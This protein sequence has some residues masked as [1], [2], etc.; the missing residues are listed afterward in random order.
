M[1][2]I[3]SKFTHYYEAAIK[4]RVSGGLLCRSAIICAG[5]DKKRKPYRRSIIRC[6]TWNAIIPDEVS[7]RP[8]VYLLGDKYSIASI[9]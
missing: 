3:K 6:M 9:K 7:N 4:Q 2:D 8:T 1:G 5:D